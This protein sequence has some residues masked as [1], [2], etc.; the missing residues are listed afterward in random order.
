MRSLCEK[1]S[2]QGVWLSLR[3]LPLLHSHQ[4]H[5]RVFLHMLRFS[6]GFVRRFESLRLQPWMLH[7]ERQIKLPGYPV[8]M[9][10]LPCHHSFLPFYPPYETGKWF[11]RLLSFIL[12]YLVFIIIT[13]YF[14]LK[15]HK[16]SH[17]ATQYHIIFKS[18]S[19]GLFIFHYFH[20]SSLLQ[21]FT[22]FYAEH[23][24]IWRTTICCCQVLIVMHQ[25]TRNYPVPPAVTFDAVGSDGYLQLKQRTYLIQLNFF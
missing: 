15:S 6:V 19:V 5:C 24:L 25:M 14:L 12:V 13:S 3:P 1:Q 22:G 9:P 2:C 8:Q 7:R 17:N 20:K 23:I 4:K 18:L 10:Q 11:S 21:P 16:N